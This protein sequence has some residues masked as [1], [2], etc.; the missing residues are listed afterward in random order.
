MRSQ[1]LLVLWATALVGL[2]VGCG[3]QYQRQN[4]V[5]GKGPTSLTFRNSGG[6][7]IEVRVTWARGDGG[8]RS[9]SFDLEPRGSVE[10][11]LVERV[12]YEVSLDAACSCPTCPTTPVCPQ[13]QV[14]E[15]GGDE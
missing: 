4:Q 2:L 5:I 1:A 13:H 6:D 3:G 15:V 12:E 7:R 10:L 11:K 9:R 8:L 14:I